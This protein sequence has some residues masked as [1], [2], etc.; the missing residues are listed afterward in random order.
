MYTY[1][2]TLYKGDTHLLRSLNF[3]SQQT[4]CGAILQKKP[5]FGDCTQVTTTCSIHC[6]CVCVCVCTCA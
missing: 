1:M 2:P 4:V 3:D 6:V 5:D